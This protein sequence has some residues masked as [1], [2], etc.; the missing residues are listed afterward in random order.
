MS[1]ER[2]KSKKESKEN[3]EELLKRSFDRWEYLKERGGSDPFWADGCNMNLIMS[4]IM[5]YKRKI[6]EFG[7]PYPEIYYRETPPETDDNYMARSDEIRENAKKALAEFEENV[8]LQYIRQ[9]VARLSD[10]ELKRLNIP[11]VIGYE[12]SL[13][14][15][16]AKD[17]LLEM[18]RYENPCKYIE[19]FEQKANALRLFEP[20][21]D[22][23]LSLF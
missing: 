21:E 5:S 19:S 1:T 12:S 7:E 3:Y 20:T 10:T 13:R 11:I 23:Q 2:N 22:V 6:E 17:D 9:E 16:I 8:N 4:H 15:A 18:R 14:T